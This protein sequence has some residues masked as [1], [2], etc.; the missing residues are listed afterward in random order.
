[1]YYTVLQSTGKKQL[2]EEALT[3]AAGR[4][5]TLRLS[6]QGDQ[7]AAPPAA[8]ENL[9]QIYEAFG[10]ENVMVVDD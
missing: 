1:M 5:L 7:P 9:S 6:L 4:P 10:R 8:K 3:Q 2:I